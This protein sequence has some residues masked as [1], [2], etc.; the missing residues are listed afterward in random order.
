MYRETIF[1]SGSRKMKEILS[2]FAIGVIVAVGRLLVS[3]EKLNWRLLLGRGILG[4][5]IGLV[6]YPIVWLT[7]VYLPVPAVIEL[8]ITIGVCCF[9]AAIG[10][11]I[12]EQ[13]IKAIVFKYTG[14]DIS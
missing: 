10:T 4:G 9:L 2:I 1:G 12:I 14:K 6:S 5:A 11:E 13:A 7:S 3:K 8:Q